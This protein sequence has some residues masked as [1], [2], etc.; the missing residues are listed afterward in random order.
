M[1]SNQGETR[2][3]EEELSSKNSVTENNDRSMS[4][5]SGARVARSK[6]ASVTINVDPLSRIPSNS[7]VTASLFCFENHTY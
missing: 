2:S 1:E 4:D 5:A 7:E 3:A 6:I